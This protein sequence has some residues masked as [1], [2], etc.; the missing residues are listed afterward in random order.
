[1]ND[2]DLYKKEK[3]FI[4]KIEEFFESVKSTENENIYETNIKYTFS[5]KNNRYLEIIIDIEN[6]ESI[7]LLDDYIEEFNFYNIELDIHTYNKI[8]EEE[9]YEIIHEYPPWYNEF[10]DILKKYNKD[11]DEYKTIFL[12]SYKND[13]GKWV[14]KTIENELIYLG[15]NKI[16]T[17]KAILGNNRIKFIINIPIN[18]YINNNEHQI[19]NIIIS[20]LRRT[21]IISENYF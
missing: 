7:Q 19:Y 18:I 1:M 2:F 17:E 8:I 11:I 3:K 4:N 5:K 13:E 14:G 21:E 16:I 6:D 20:F 15:F 10:K 12:P 9:K